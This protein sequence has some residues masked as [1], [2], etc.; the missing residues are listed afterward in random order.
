LNNG[1][2][3]SFTGPITFANYDDLVKFVPLESMMIETDSPYAAPKSV[4]GKRNDPRNVI[5][6]GAKI[7]QIKGLSEEEVFTQI[8][9]N[10]RRVFGV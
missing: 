10:T 2:T 5:E 8:R 9:E 4:R 1:F 7:A 6:I 3:V